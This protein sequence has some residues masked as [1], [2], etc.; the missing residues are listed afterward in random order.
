MEIQKN[1]N[2]PHGDRIRQNKEFYE[3]W[4]LPKLKLLCEKKGWETPIIKHLY[5][6][7]E[8]TA[9]D[10]HAVSVDGISVEV[11]VEER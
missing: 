6:D 9:T 2:C 10:F 4:L 3:S 11:G 5:A 8:N 1:T 7:V